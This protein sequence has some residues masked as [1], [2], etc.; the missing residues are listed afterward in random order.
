M[1]KNKKIRINIININ[2]YFFIQALRID[3]IHIYYK[4]NNCIHIKGGIIGGSIKRD[5]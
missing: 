2:P 5:V 3:I 4:C 1:R